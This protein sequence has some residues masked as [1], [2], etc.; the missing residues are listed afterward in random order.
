L[1]HW[2]KL[3]GDGK[4]TWG[5]KSAIEP[6]NWTITDME[7]ADPLLTEIGLKQAKVVNTAWKEQINNG[8]PLPE[9]LYS[10]PLTRAAH[11]ALL[12]FDDIL[13]NVDKAIHKKPLIKEVRQID[14]FS[15]RRRN[16][17]RLDPE[18]ERSE[19]STHM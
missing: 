6:P 17:I 5:R 7:L 4:M 3:N 10:S 8:M 1:S 2:A 11:T 18:I 15:Y 13:I 14:L 12:T 9:S 16:R 19:R